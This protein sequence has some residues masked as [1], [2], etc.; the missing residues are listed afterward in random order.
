MRDGSP[1][2]PMGFQRLRQA[3]I[4]ILKHRYYL[5]FLPDPAPHRPISL[6]FFSCPVSDA[7]LEVS[8]VATAVGEGKKTRSVVLAGLPFPLVEATIELVRPVT[9]E[10]AIVE[11]SLVDATVAEIEN[12]SSMPLVLE[13]IS[14]VD[15][16][17]IP[18][19]SPVAMTDVV[20]EGPLV[21]VSLCTGP[22][23]EAVPSAL[24]PVSLVPEST[25]VHHVPE[26]VWEAF[27]GRHGSDEVTAV[28]VLV[29]D[30]TV[31]N[32]NGRLGSLDFGARY[33]GFLED[34]LVGFFGVQRDLLRW[35]MFTAILP[36]GMLR[37][38]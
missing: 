16:P 30:A 35:G 36:C 6:G 20:H 19:V 7:V 34:T 29:K 25:A 38:I 2:M 12:T 22:F 23:T 17:V 28:P 37:M 18:G 13:E 8:S 24:L 10:D 21:A 32:M 4:P 26:A 1:R 15:I 11:V 27:L 33:E 9:F 5:P 14:L 31:V 3:E